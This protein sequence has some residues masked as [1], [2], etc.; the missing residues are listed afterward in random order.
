GQHRPYHQ[1]ADAAAID[2][3][4]FHLEALPPELQLRVAQFV[5]MPEIGA[6]NQ[7]S[8][9]VAAHTQP[10]LINRQSARLHFKMEQFRFSAA[11]GGIMDFDFD[12]PI[13]FLAGAAPTS[14]KIPV[15][16]NI[17]KT[18]WAAMDTFLPRSTWA[19]KPH[20]ELNFSMLIESC[21]DNMSAADKVPGQRRAL[22]MTF[23]AALLGAERP[24]IAITECMNLCP[25]FQQPVAEE[26]LCALMRTIRLAA[27]TD[28]PTALREVAYHFESIPYY[29][30]SKL[31]T[32]AFAICV[33][34]LIGQQQ[35]RAF[36]NLA[37]KTVG[38]LAA[39]EIVSLKLPRRLA[40]TLAAS[41]KQIHDDPELTHTTAAQMQS[42][43]DLCRG[44]D[45][46]WQSA[47]RQALAASID[48][49]DADGTALR[50]FIGR[51]GTI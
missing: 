35:L 20:R 7:T 14:K 21:L 43:L 17:F 6:L 25:C 8:T 42:L 4:Q 31:A 2:A 1:P 27:F 39:P 22:Q 16:V 30:R 29:L 28:K 41:V 33:R 32:E 24:P 47:L 34:V 36:A 12:L 13:K 49:I 38:A 44:F 26:L 45:P 51:T 48:F 19:F 40:I 18:F 3:P 15:S 37:G 10:E 11:R 5:G 23:F 9:G 46:H 50:R